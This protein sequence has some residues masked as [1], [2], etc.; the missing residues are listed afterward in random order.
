MG[1]RITGADDVMGSPAYM[2]PEQMMASPSLDGRSDIWSMGA[3]LY[4]LLT[5]KL[6]FPG[7]TAFQM[8]SNA[9]A[10]P[11]IPM[12]AIVPGIPASVQAIVSTCLRKEPGERYATMPELARAL[13]SALS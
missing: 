8:F 7:E 10:R 6:P 11:P 4:E 5:T 9:M 12:S 2:S 13:R 1:T 3:L